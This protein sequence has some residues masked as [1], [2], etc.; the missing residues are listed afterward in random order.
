MG[1]LGGVMDPRITGHEE[2]TILLG[3][4]S[5]REIARTRI[6]VRSAVTVRPRDQGR[7]LGGRPPYGYRL[8]RRGPSPFTRVPRIRAPHPQGTA[9]A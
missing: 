8:R 9:E 3:T 7:V 2:L 5:K 6:R 4:L 1:R